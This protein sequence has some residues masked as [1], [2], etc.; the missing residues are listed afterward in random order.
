MRLE[1]EYSRDHFLTFIDD[2][3]PQFHRDARDVTPGSKLFSK[4]L[5][6]G[7]D[8]SLEL[9]VFEVTID[10]SI[11]KRITITTDAFKLMKQYQAYRALIIF[12]AEGNTS[13]RLSL[14]TSKPTIENGKVIS[15]LSNPR[16]YSYLL[17]PKAKV[18]TPRKFLSAKVIDFEDL[19]K[20]FSLEV[21]NKEFYS[22]ISSAYAR[23]I[24]NKDG[25][26][27]LTLPGYSLSDKTFQQFAVRLLGR[28]IFCWFL[29]QKTSQQGPLIPDE[30]LSSKIVEGYQDYYHEILEPL[31][32]ETLNTEI[33]SRN[34]KY[35]TD[36]WIN[37]PYLNGGLFNPDRDSDYYEIDHLT[38]T[39][40]H[41]DTL[42]IANTW[43]LELFRILE[44][45]NFTID[46]NT[47]IDQELS[48]DPE[49]LGRIFENL[50]AEEFNEETKE[51]ARK[52]T[53]S[54]YTPRQI[55]EYMVDESLVQFLQMNTKIS[56]E[57][58][59]A[60]V[61]YDETDD[62]EHPISDDEIDLIIKAIGELKIL[63]PACGSGAYP[64]GILQKVIY[65]LQKLDPGAKK[66]LEAKISSIPDEAFK[67]RLRNDYRNKSLDYIRK[68]FV[69]KDSIYGV[70]IQ[71][72]AVEVAKLRCFLTLIIDEDINDS[73]PNRGI[74]TLPNLDFK[75][76]AAN[77]LIRP[78]L[79][80][81]GLNLDQDFERRLER[82]IESYFQPH[83]SRAKFDA[84]KTIDEL[85]EQKS[86]DEFKQAF[87]MQARYYDNDVFNK[88]RAQANAKKMAASL[89]RAELWK[90]YKNILRH[91][92][93][94]FF[95]TKYFFP[96]VKDGFDIIIGN[97][98]YIQL[99]NNG[100]ELADM[101]KDEGFDTFIR[102]GD[103]YSLFFERGMQL[104]KPFSGVICYIT[105]NKWMRAGYGEKTR[106]YIL[107]YDPLKL[108]DFGGFKVFE[109]AT[110]DTSILLLQH[111]HNKEVLQAAH[112]KNDYSKDQPI[113][114]YFT[115]NKIYLDVIDSSSWFIGN[116]LE[117]K[118]KQKVEAIGS[119]LK[120]WDVEIF[121]GIL[122]GCN[123][124]FVIDES[125]R[126]RLIEE[127]PN[128]Q[129]IIKP[130]LRGRDISRYSIN[131]QGMY[132]LATGYDKDIKNEYPAIYRH[133]KRIG[134]MIA[135]KTI[136]VKGKGVYDRDDQGL[137]WWNLRA[138][139]YY[140]KFD[141]PKIV[142]P[143]I[144]AKAS[145]Y[146]DKNGHYLNDKAFM[147]L[148]DNLSYIIAFL[149]SSFSH[150]YMKMIGSPLGRD[151]IEYRK[152]YLDEYPIPKITDENRALALELTALVDELGA[153][154]SEKSLLAKI[155]SL[156]YR[157]YGLS[158]DE[159]KSIEEK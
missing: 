65:I 19:Q 58:L 152:I 33:S 48:I 127:D 11:D 155:D 80:S 99:Q 139:S 125:T 126:Q 119:P 92:T 98:P 134:D 146:L 78:P 42:K 1:Q 56:L 110:V 71:P 107:K 106:K 12:K 67:E 45:Y 23:L 114:E 3:L 17:G 26:A 10:S 85:I 22:A 130:L 28:I 41:V 153:S 131:F 64:M 95:E 61:S 9:T 25:G 87:S 62:L 43:F 147:I 103:I 115:N 77:T 135:D 5:Q 37:I 7:S 91:K 31:F 94:G 79:L 72:I 16:R 20:R 47:M 21:V 117:Q 140:S 46:E 35:K 59:Q 96:A 121:R 156:V 54:F 76:V 112:F 66:W 154:G 74:D 128:S 8:D 81:T 159:I 84:W 132:V 29:K 109:S 75:F 142:Y 57:K 108:I 141:L 51:S 49:M 158:N 102:T 18:A 69:I 133:I 6:L 13:W 120:E 122:T 52:S 97:P 70:D 145:F 30:L 14:L 104:L 144:T 123:E 129:D 38:K 32:F 124:A 90:S 148:G 55:V 24:G 143:V 36:P 27:Q 118:I 50:L 73:E 105:S 2:F 4:V 111:S 101:Y 44:T 82:A 157:L 149:N 138:C 39:S 88:A 113:N 63:D 137:N 150:K 86:E 53:G 89:N 60:L 116:P 100:G 34:D 68:S 151:G 93:V 15:K 83:S 40:L 136:K